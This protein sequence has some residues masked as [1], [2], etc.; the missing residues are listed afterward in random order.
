MALCLSRPPL[1]SS[2]SS[3]LP[4]LL[5]FPRSGSHLA[6]KSRRNRRRVLVCASGTKGAKLVTF[7]GKGGS[8]K[9]TAAV[10][11]AQ[12]MLIPFPL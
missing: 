8:G 11:A 9:T 4:F 3:P 12:V 7:V 2:P 1:F 5:C 6:G 10:L